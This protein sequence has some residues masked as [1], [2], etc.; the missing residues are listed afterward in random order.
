MFLEIIL[1]AGRATAAS[2]TKATAV[3]ATAA[4][5]SAATKAT[6]AA[7]AR[8]HWACFIDRQSAAIIV[9]AIELGDR[10]SCFCFRGHFHETKALGATRVAIGDDLCRLNRSALSESVI[11][12]LIGC[13]ERQIAH[14]KFLTHIYLLKV[15]Q[16]QGAANE[17]M[18]TMPA[19][20]IVANELTRP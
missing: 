5:E 18:G 7:F 2:A 12:N 13:R 4:A 9:C 20:S 17:D 15:G 6:T 10:V 16:G 14:V 8:S 11:E 1:E 3:A 19:V